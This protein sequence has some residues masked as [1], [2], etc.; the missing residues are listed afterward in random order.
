MKNE[1]TMLQGEGSVMRRS[2][3]TPRAAAVA[4]ILFALLYGTGPALIR[5]S[6][7]DQNAA[8]GGA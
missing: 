7:P 3:K 8:V 4:G 2:L 1:E 6:T 5:L